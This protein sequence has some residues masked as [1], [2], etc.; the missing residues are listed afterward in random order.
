MARPAVSEEDAVIETW[1]VAFPGEVWVWVY[2]RRNDEY[3]KQLVSQRTGSKMLH[4]SRDDRKYNQ[5]LIPDECKHLDPFVNGLLRLLGAATRDEN[6]DVRNHYSNDDLI[7]MFEVRDGALFEEA[8]E[9]LTS[10]IVL[11]RLM[12]LADDHGTVTQNNILRELIEKRFPVGGTQKTV[13]E[14]YEAGER[15]GAGRI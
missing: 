13:R 15:I 1:E 3:K 7:G 9:D 2:D 12:T 6:L 11:R 4:I 5:E 14:M 10:E 8:L